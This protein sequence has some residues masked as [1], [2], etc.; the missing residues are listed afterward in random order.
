M[1]RIPIKRA[2]I[3]VSDKSGLLPLAEALVASGAE[4]VSSGGT[5]AHLESSGIPVTK[6]AAVTD[7]PEM[8][9]GRV[10]TLHPSIHGGILADL[11]LDEHRADL[12]ERGIEPFGLVVTSLYPFEATVESGASEADIIEQIDIGGPTLIRSAAKNHAWVAV[13]TAPDRYGDII[14]AITAGGTTADLRLDLARE[15]FFRTASYDAAIVNWFEREGSERLVL[16][17]TMRSPLRYGENPQQPAALYSLEDSQG[18]WATATQIQGKEMSFNNY[19]DADAAWRLAHDLP[20]PAVVVVKHMNACGAATGDTMVDAFHKAW[21]GDPLA[22]FGGVVALSGHLDGETAT[23]IAALFVEIVI[24]TGITDDAAEIL[25]PRQ[26]LRVLIAGPPSDFDLDVRTI[27][28]GFL[29][30]KRDGTPSSFDSWESMTRAPTATERSDL[31][32]AWTICAHTKSNAIVLVRDGAAVG[33][34]AGDQSRVGAAERALVKAGERARGAVC[35]SDAFFPFRDG[36][37]TLAAA[38]VTAIVEPGGSV[39]DDEVV[40]SAN[41]HDVALLFT[42]QRHFRH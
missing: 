5:A 35:A 33:V 9:G 30:Q 17:M 40:E 27:D 13:V 14:E 20:S 4:I 42:G 11:G 24:A 12:A 1:N 32:I 6:V 28:D 23:A 8:L 37:D 19:A 7:A 18:W 15:A 38:G 36:P 3:S 29:I 41:E 22:A 26:N 16:P 21:S 39:R 25:K 31:E 34:G 2:L 10:K